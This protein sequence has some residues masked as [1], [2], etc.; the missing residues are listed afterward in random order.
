V[1]TV[2]AATLLTLGGAATGVAAA[3]LSEPRTVATAEVQNRPGA[4]ALDPW[5]ESHVD[6]SITPQARRDLR[7]SV[8]TARSTLRADLREAGY[9]AAARDAALA[10]YRASVALAVASFDTATLPP[11][12]VAPVAAYR[13]AIRT[14]EDN[15]RTALREADT[16]RDQARTQA[17]LDLRQALRAADTADERW[18]AQ[19]AYREAMIAAQR[20]FRDAT[21]QART[22]AATAVAAARADL[23]AALAS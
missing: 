7:T 14:A 23:T 18:A 19:A 17:R 5:L 13:S 12:Q 8:T 10:N 11:A 22:A 21:S 3:D 1:A 6:R 2:A 20:A 9:D 4:P 15:A 16:A